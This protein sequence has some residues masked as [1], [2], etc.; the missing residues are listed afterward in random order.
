MRERL[1]ARRD[2]L[3]TELKAGQE[4]LAELDAKRAE[5]QQT[6]LRISGAIQVLGELIEE[7]GSAGDG[8]DERSPG[9]VSQLH[10]VGAGGAGAGR[11]TDQPAA[12][13]VSSSSS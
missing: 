6:L 4:M 2:E 12:G 7:A 13:P 9:G 5:V 11:S 8:P 10:T 1:E 3:A